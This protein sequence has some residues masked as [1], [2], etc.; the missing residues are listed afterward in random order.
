MNVVSCTA[1]ITESP[2]SVTALVDTNARFHCAGTGRSV[3]FWTVQFSNFLN[4]ENQKRER[5][6]LAFRRFERIEY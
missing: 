5:V 3:Y 4:F 2:V 6:L 1:A